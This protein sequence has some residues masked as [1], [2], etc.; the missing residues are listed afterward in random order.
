MNKKLLSAPPVQPATSTARRWQRFLPL[1]LTCSLP[2]LL[3]AENHVDYRYGYYDETGDRM[4]IET[5][6]VYFEQKLIDSVTAKGELTYDGVSGATPNGT[7][8][9]DGSVNTTHMWDLRRAESLELDCRLYNH[10]LT[11]G[12]SHSEEH[13]YKSDGISLNDAIEFND[14]NTILQLG[15]VNTKA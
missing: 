11:P 15:R 7:L 5:H 2:Q 8:N 12:Y 1:G 3:R 13:D 4:K 9:A 6:S 14:K 10:T